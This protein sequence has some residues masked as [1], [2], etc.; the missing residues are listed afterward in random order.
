MAVLKTVFDVV[1][2]KIAGIRGREQS[3]DHRIFEALKAADIGTGADAWLHGELFKRKW[4]LFKAKPD[5]SVSKSEGQSLSNNFAFFSSLSKA[6][7]GK[8]PELEVRHHLSK[9]AKDKEYAEFIQFMRSHVSELEDAAKQNS[10]RNYGL[11]V[12]KAT[13]F[14]RRLTTGDHPR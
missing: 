2:D 6:R 9:L 11:P 10:V 7:F 14:I 3:T 5:F 13:D 4:P 8:F 12:A 1:A